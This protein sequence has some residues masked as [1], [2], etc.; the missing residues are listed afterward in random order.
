MTQNGN[1]S[2]SWRSLTTEELADI[3]Q[4]R[5]QT[6]D[7]YQTMASLL[8]SQERAE[9]HHS[10]YAREAAHEA[11]KR[12]TPRTMQALQIA[13]QN[14]DEALRQR[15]RTQAVLGSALAELT[16][17]VAR[18][19]R[20][21][22]QAEGIVGDHIMHELEVRRMAAF[23]QQAVLQ[24]LIDYQIVLCVAS[25]MGELRTPALMGRTRQLLSQLGVETAIGPDTP[26]ALYAL[27]DLVAG[28]PVDRWTPPPA[29]EEQKGEG[30][31][32]EDEVAE[33]PP[34]LR[35]LRKHDEDEE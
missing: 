28:Q 23:V 15:K 20:E 30:I 17:E 19:A 14:R 31:V 29:E 5:N 13:E 33:E 8:R 9:R 25:E 35:M 16:V 4:L 12:P 32:T 6:H 18:T 2:A 7:T 24:Q 11:T 27:L 34:V 26:E 1:G 22:A 10:K 3:D 21:L